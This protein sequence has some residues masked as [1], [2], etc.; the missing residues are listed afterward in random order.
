MAAVTSRPP[1]DDRVHWLDGVRG[2]AAVFVVLHH[3]WLSTWPGFPSNTGPWWLGWLLYGHMAVAIFI[4]VSGFSLALAPLSRGGWLAGGVRRFIRRRAWR[5]LPPYWAA[6]VLSIVVSSLF[7]KPDLGSAVIAKT[8]VVH[9]FLLQDVVDSDSPNGALW[10]IAVE[11]QIYFLF[12]LILLLGLR[13]NLSTAVLVTVAAVLL[14]HG[15]AGTGAP[16]DKINHLTPQFLALFALGVLA[17]QLGS[18][19]RG[20]KLRRPLTAVA[21]AALAA[22]VIAA[23]RSG[24]E[25]M[26]AHFFWMDLLFG[27]GVACTLTVLKAGGGARVRAVLA[28]RP[29]LWLG[30]FSYSIYLV[31]DPILGVMSRYGFA[32]L[33]LSPLATFGVTLAVGLPLILAF[34]YGFHLLFEA[35]FLRRRD[36]SALRTLPVL[37]LL[38]RRQRRAGED[39]RGRG[40]VS[41]APAAGEQPAG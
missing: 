2:G 38:P 17:V 31:H 4:V 27:L 6:L 3:M 24:P 33:G 29:A 25:W 22:F 19:D 37:R 14:A 35:P 30:L 16:F 32:Q 20:E 15:I 23:V 26:V 40:I 11:W 12:P 21:L 1:R 9:G 34:C 5:I 10:S 7:L 41:P 8:F 28:S 36:L 13:T 39:E 18:G